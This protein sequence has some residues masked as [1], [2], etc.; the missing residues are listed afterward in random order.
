[1]Y[2]YLFIYS[3]IYLSSFIYLF[4]QTYI[5]LFIYSL[6]T[7]FSFF[8]S[9]WDQKKFNPMPWLLYL[10][11]LLIYLF[12]HRF[13][14]FFI[15]WCIYYLTPVYLFGN[16]AGIIMVLNPAGTTRGHC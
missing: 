3:Y 15:Y 4:I 6:L 5:Y 11:F 2:F 12:I 8:F 10:F 9:F 14:W 13:I 16:S 7:I 1:M